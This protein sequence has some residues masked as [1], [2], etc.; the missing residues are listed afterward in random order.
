MPAALGSPAMREAGRDA[1]RHLPELR[2]LRL[3]RAAAGRGALSPGLSPVHADRER[4]RVIQRWPGKA[5]PAGMSAMPRWS[6]CT[7]R[8]SRALLPDDDDLCRDTGAGG[9]PRKLAAVWVPKLT[10]ARVR[11]CVRRWSGKTGATL[12]M[13]MTEKQ[14]GSDV[15]ANATGRGADGDAWRLTGHKWF[16]SA[17]MS[18]G[19][20][21][22]AQA[23]GGLTCFL[24]PRW[25]DGA[26]NGIQL[27]R[28]KDKL[29]NRSN[30]SAEI[31]YHGALAYRLG[32]PGAGGPDDHRHGASHQAGHRAGAGG[33]DAGGA[34]RGAALG[35]A[36]Q[37]VPAPAGRPAA[38]AGGAG[39]SGAGLGGRAGA[40]AAGGAGV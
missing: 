39:R 20:L 12:G 19:F 28:L 17:P 35:A 26:R 14:G 4:R 34:G 37:R 27:M 16:C 3:R 13:A 36:P 33:A 30:A 1:N 18:D 23:P 7:A 5:R 38:D 6:T 11:P 2:Q 31:E 15:R 21:T 22:L 25:L 9:R 40:G 10:V 24:V 8:S 29:G 32:E